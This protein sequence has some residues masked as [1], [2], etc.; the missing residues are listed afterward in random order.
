[1]EN[2]NKNIILSILNKLYVLF[3]CGEK[4]LLCGSDEFDYTSFQVSYKIGILDLASVNRIYMNM[5]YLNSK[6]GKYI[7]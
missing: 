2:S 5:K 1:M 3:W 7:N 6:I 4:Y